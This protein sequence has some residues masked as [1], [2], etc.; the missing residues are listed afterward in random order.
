LSGYGFFLCREPP[1][2]ALGKVS[3]SFFSKFFTFR[4]SIKKIYISLCREPPDMALGKVFFEKY[5]ISV[6]I[7]LKKCAI[8]LLINLYT[9]RSFFKKNIYSLPSVSC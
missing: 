3:F 1:D 4:F 7:F 2:L 5:L 6:F 9:N 8:F